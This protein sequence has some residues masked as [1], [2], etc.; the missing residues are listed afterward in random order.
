MGVTDI[1]KA[2]A[3]GRQIEVSQH[4]GR[5]PGLEAHADGKLVHE[6]QKGD[7]WFALARD[8]NRSFHMFMDWKQLRDANPQT[9]GSLFPGQQLTIPHLDVLFD[10]RFDTEHP[11]LK[12]V[13][14]KLLHKVRPGDTL[15][16]IARNYSATE[17]LN[18]TWQSVYAANKDVI[19]D[20]P[21]LI[22]PGQLL[23]IPGITRMNASAYRSSIKDLDGVQIATRA[24]RLLHENR[25]VSVEDVMYYKVD[26][27][28]A[29]EVGKDLNTAMAR[30]KK[31]LGSKTGFEAVIQTRSGSYWV[32]PMD[33]TEAGNGDH[34]DTTLSLQVRRDERSLVGYVQRN[35]DGTY[36]SRKFES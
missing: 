25:E 28:K 29:K 9:N 21:N 13:G 27:D 11:E 15:S 26:T 20:N 14:D 6:V 36:N 22:K 33:G 19:G 34:T 30:A 12:L 7:S 35:Y 18:L 24:A 17:G 2:H 23:K 31:E 10:I 8:Y 5:P 4:P 3:M 1:V 32:V 16:A